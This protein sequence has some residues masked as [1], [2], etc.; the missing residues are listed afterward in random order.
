MKQLA[1]SPSLLLLLFGLAG[2]GHRKLAIVQEL[3]QQEK[4][5]KV[6]LHDL[7]KGRWLLRE[8]A[9]AAITEMGPAAE[10]AVPALLRACKRGRLRLGAMKALAAIGERASSAIPKLKGYLKSQYPLVRSAAQD[11]LLAIG[12]DAVPFIARDIAGKKFF[13]QAATKLANL[14][15]RGKSAVRALAAVVK[16]YPKGEGLTIPNP[17][18]KIKRQEKIREANERRLIALVALS[19]MGGAKSGAMPALARAMYNKNRNIAALA[20]RCLASCGDTAVPAL[21]R[22]LKKKDY[23]WTDLTLTAL[24]A[25]GPAAKKALPHIEKLSRKSRGS[26]ARP[27]ADAQLAIES[28]LELSDM[29]RSQ[30]AAQRKDAALRLADYGDVATEG[31]LR[32]LRDQDLSIRD[33][34][35]AKMLDK[36]RFV[37]ETLN[38]GKPVQAAWPPRPALS[39][40]P[41]VSYFVEVL[42]GGDTKAQL[43]V[44]RILASMGGKERKHTVDSLLRACGRENATLR[45]AALRT[46]LSFELRD[47][48]GIAALGRAMHGR[49]ATFRLNILSYLEKIGKAAKAASKALIA[50][51]RFDDAKVQEIACKILVRLKLAKEL[52]ATLS[53]ADPTQR[54][55]I[56]KCLA[57]FGKKARSTL[58][59]LQA[60]LDAEKDLGAH[61]ALKAAIK[62]IERGK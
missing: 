41:F 5:L 52:A 18:K 47:S 14:G 12:F 37:T 26:F 36:R 30:D 57:A 22:T 20:I 3:Q 39:R 8:R 48:Q 19:H 4:S 13:R 7:D 56:A 60:A 40:Q 53:T 38:S 31:V 24:K 1:F 25:F 16:Y 32:A 51:L 29:I 9:I 42:E 43:M 27:A 55:A 46:L 34:L 11:S 2:P 35:L 21:I 59:T 17:K 54:R 62:S 61:E 58:E 45:K 49:T 6:L 28:S 33:A 15:E 10:D 50:S 23:M 44:C